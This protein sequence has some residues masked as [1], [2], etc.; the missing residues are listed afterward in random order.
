ME[1]E[2]RRRL[3]RR[4]GLEHWK[5][6][7][8]RPGNPE[9]EFW[10]TWQYII[11]LYGFGCTSDEYQHEKCWGWT[12]LRTSYDDDEA[13]TQAVAAIQR[14]ALVRLEDEYRESRTRGKP[15]NGGMDAVKEKLDKVP[16]HPNLREH[17]QQAWSAMVGP[18]Q[19]AL[20]EGEPL[21]PDWVITHEL[22]RR[23]HHVILQD[24]Q[25]LDGADARTPRLEAYSKAWEYA[26]ALNLGE[27]E[28]IARGALMAPDDRSKTAWEYRVKVVSTASEVTED[29]DD[30]D[31]M[32]EFPL[33]RRR[34]RLYDFFD[35]FIYLCEGDLDEM[36]VEGW[37][38]ERFVGHEE[39][40][41]E[42]CRNR[43]ATGVRAPWLRE[44]YGEVVLTA[45]LILTVLLN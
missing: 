34:M 36:A 23:Y 9:R 33:G 18:A 37:D 7:H 22:V 2:D 3:E 17:I 4:Y 24:S 43:W 8:F 15:D 45:G 31:Q 26:Y 12:I 6:G 38:R 21:T 25:A 27:R 30:T 35:T 20:P 42:L 19:D 13:F 28:E 32:M 1:D 16:G 29:G 40:E 39:R 41:W 10:Q 14:L 11:C 5:E 44:L